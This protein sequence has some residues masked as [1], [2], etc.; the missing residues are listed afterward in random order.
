[1]TQSLVYRFSQTPTTLQN[2][3]SVY[4]SKDH[5]NYANISSGRA[6]ILLEPSEALR[7]QLDWNGSY[8]QGL[9]SPQDTPAYAGGPAPWDPRITLPATGTYQNANSTLASY[10]RHTNLT[11]LDVSY[12]FGFATL[13]STTAYGETSAVTGQDDN[14]QIFGLPET[15]L[16]YYV[17]NPINPRF[18]GTNNYTDTEYRF[19]QELRLVSKPGEHFD[20]VAG[21]FYEHDPRNL[22]WD[23]YEA[24]ITAQSVAAGSLYVNTSP[25][26]HTFYEHAPQ[27]FTE[28]ALYG[29]LTWHLSKRWQI[30]GGGRFFH[31]TLSQ[32]Q[33]FYS[34]IISQAG[35]NNSSNSTNRQIFKLNTSYEFVDNNQ[36]YATFSQGFRRGGVNAFP[37][38]GFYQESPEILNYKP[39]TTDNYEIGVKG[40]SEGGLHYS[41][42]I[43]YI[44]WNDPQMGVSTPNTWPVVINGKKAV[45]KGF[46]GEITTPLFV[47]NLQLMLSYAYTHARLTEAFCLPGGDGTGN[48]NGF[49]PC[50]ISGTDDQRLP[51]TPEQNGFCDAH[52]Q[53]APWSWT[54]NRVHNN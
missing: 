31:D 35:G 33:N 1:M 37:L 52:L 6:S 28:Y 30:T 32:N 54:R 3:S 40:V 46:E 13:S 48:P 50:G 29:E 4:Y 27:V 20:Y 43:F 17:G 25:D 26:G 14:V 44:N 22:D 18:V 53:P 10:Y 49:Y 45:S 8:V 9:N 21:A 34:Y 11:D 12:D 41:T 51:G 23:I 24:G 47:K 2:S 42:D 19:T 5:A 7:I 16:P 38:T 15:Y 36:V 39:D